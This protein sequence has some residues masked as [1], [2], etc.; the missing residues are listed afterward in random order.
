M[1]ADTHLSYDEDR[2]NVKRKGLRIALAVAVGFS[3]S[4]YSGAIIPF[5]GPLFAAQFLISSSRRPCCHACAVRQT[6]RGCLD[7]LPP[8]IRNRCVTASGVCRRFL[9]HPGHLH[10]GGHSLCDLHDN[11]ALASAGA[12]SSLNA[13]RRLTRHFGHVVVEHWGKQHALTAVYSFDE[14]RH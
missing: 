3:W 2:A 7:D 12:Q 13:C 4:V 8:R 14:T 11:V 10:I 6:L 5:L 9:F 1:S